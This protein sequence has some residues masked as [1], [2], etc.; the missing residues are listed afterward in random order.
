MSSPSLVSRLA[1]IS[2]E[3]RADLSHRAAAF[4][5]TNMLSSVGTRGGWSGG[6]GDGPLPTPPCFGASTST[7]ED[8]TPVVPSVTRCEG[9]DGA[10]KRA[11]TQ[12]ANASS[13]GLSG[14]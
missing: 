8:D 4:C 6:N 11:A 2:S 7:T 3:P 10:A 5:A 9:N 12:R 13:D 14:K 1:A